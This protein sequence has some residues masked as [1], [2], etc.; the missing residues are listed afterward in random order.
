MPFGYVAALHV[1]PVEKK[2][3]FH[4]LPGAQGALLRHARLR[5]PLRL[6]PELAD[7]AGAA[8][9]GGDRAGPGAVDAGRDRRRRRSEHGARIVTSTYNEPLI[10]SEWAVAVFRAREGAGLRLLL[11]L[12]RQR[13]PGGAR[14]PAP[15]ACRSTRSTSRASA[16]GPTATSAARSS[17]CSGRSARCTRGA[18]GSRWSRWSCPGFNDSTE[19]LTRHR[20]LP[21]LGLARH[22]LA[23]HRL[24]PRLQDDR[25][26]GDTGRGRCCGRRRSGAAAGLRFVYAGN[27]P[28]AVRRW[29]NTYCPG[30]RRAARRAARLPGAAEPG[31]R[32]GPL[33]RLPAAVPGVWGSA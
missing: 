6:L 23:R 14:L 22:P 21:R 13:H 18:S 29:E 12:E 27:L 10:T 3:F 31:R 25:P 24:P 17:A 28:G 32:D 26:P 8:R 4:A 7:L 2:P 19:E 9:P 1:D 15:L 16:T 30:C 20:A 33:P 11:R 5:L